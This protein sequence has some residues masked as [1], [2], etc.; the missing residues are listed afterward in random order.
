[1]VQTDVQMS[2]LSDRAR[3]FKLGVDI[4]S[5]FDGQVIYLDLEADWEYEIVEAKGRLNAGELDARVKIAGV[6]VAGLDP[7]NIV[8][9][10]V[11]K[12]VPTATGPAIIAKNQQLR[13]DIEVTTGMTTPEKF[14]F[15]LHC[16]AT[17]DLTA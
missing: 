6:D 16:R 15:E 2:E 3:E 11:R 4:D 7:F 9:G 5:P 1:M 14:K 17:K 8:T 10:A 13:V 12:Q